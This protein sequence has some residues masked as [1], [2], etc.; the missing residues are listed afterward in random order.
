MKNLGG[1]KVNIKTQWL[2]S[3]VVAGSSDIWSFPRC[4]HDGMGSSAC[5]LQLSL[6]RLR[7][8]VLTMMCYQKP[9]ELVTFILEERNAGFFYANLF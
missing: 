5:A 1:R 6:E 4:K 9:V 2:R 8:K 3:L 7:C